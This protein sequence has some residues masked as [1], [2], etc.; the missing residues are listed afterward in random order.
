MLGNSAVA[1]ELDNSD[2]GLLRTID[3]SAAEEDGNSDKGP[4]RTEGDSAAEVEVGS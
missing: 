3:D 4:L 2:D 1:E